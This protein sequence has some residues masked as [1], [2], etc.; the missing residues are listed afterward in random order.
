MYICMWNLCGKQMGV[1]VIYK[2]RLCNSILSLSS[3]W[4]LGKRL[5]C[6]FQ[7]QILLRGR[8]EW[9]TW[10]CWSRRLSNWLLRPNRTNPKLKTRSFSSGV[11][12]CALVWGGPHKP[13]RAQARLNGLFKRFCPLWQWSFYCPVYITW[14]LFDLYRSDT[15]RSELAELAK[16][17]NP[18][19]ID[20]DDDDEDA[21]DGEPDG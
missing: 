10:G 12:S 21:E 6:V 20:I 16:Q 11:Y 3:V 5:C 17:A 19:E 9:M 1:G 14:H 8:A 7:C 18:D 2:L 13:I 15:S 4:V